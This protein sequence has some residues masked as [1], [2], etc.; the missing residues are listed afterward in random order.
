MYIFKLR[1]WDN[2]LYKEVIKEV[3]AIS[4]LQA[5]DYGEEIENDSGYSLEFEGIV[6]DR[7][8]RYYVNKSG[9]L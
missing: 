8:Y 9:E 3:S 7:F 5:M 4:D 6:H 1:F 2:N